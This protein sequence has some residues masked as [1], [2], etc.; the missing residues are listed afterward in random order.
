[1]IIFDRYHDC[2]NM[3]QYISGKGNLCITVFILLTKNRDDKIMMWHFWGSVPNKRVF[4]HLMDIFTFC[5]YQKHP[6]FVPKQAWLNSFVL[7]E[8][9]VLTG[10]SLRCSLSLT[11]CFWWL[12]VPQAQAMGGYELTRTV[13]DT[14]ATYKFTP[15]S[16]IKV[17]QTVTVNHAVI[18]TAHNPHTTTN[19]H[20]LRL[21]CNYS[22]YYIHLILQKNGYKVQFKCI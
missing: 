11:L 5:P 4:L 21:Y 18:L 22:Y 8:R 17:D 1:M 3:F 6:L 14:S 19:Q 12:P 20:S 7:P 10:S 2:H 16:V 13:G 9:L 15:K